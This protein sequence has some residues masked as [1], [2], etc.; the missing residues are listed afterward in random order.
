MYYEYFII[1]LFVL[2]FAASIGSFLNVI[3]YRIPNKLFADEKEYAKEIL[4]QT[5]AVDTDNSNDKFS[6]LEPSRCPKCDNK[7]KY[8]H[9][10]PIF[11]WFLLKGKCYFCKCNIPFIYPFVEIITSI[12]FI[13]IVYKYGLTQEGYGLL[14]LASFFIA[15]FFID[16][17]HQ[18]LPDQL[19]LPLLWIG[20][21][22]NIFDTYVPLQE[23]VIG[24]I[25]GYMSLWSIFW[26][27]KLITKKEG[28]G[29]GDFKLLAAVGAWFGYSMLM[30]TIFMSCMIGLVIALLTNIFNRKTNTIAF[31][32]SIILACIFYLITK[33]NIY[34][35]YNHIMMIHP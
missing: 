35:W 16:Q 28:F 30:Y 26:I 34:V 27:Y 20:I 9:N 24:A 6:L 23:S 29:Y 22:F 12:I 10:I 18:I 31:G 8:K 5:S 4:N 3:I 2:L 17:E 7:L 25:I 15:L 21:G 33:D 1:L 11:G 32:P 19:T 14:I 13:A